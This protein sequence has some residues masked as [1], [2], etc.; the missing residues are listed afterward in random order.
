METCISKGTGV[1]LGLLQ[2]KYF[3]THHECLWDAM[4]VVGVAMRS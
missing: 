3:G 2:V 1:A 4:G